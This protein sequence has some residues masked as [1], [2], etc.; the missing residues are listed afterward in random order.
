[1]PVPTPNDIAA[2]LREHADS[3]NH[4]HHDDN[5]GAY[6]NLY[7]EAATAIDELQDIVDKLP[8]CS[9]LGDDGEVVQDVPVVP[10]MTVWVIHRLNRLWHHRVSQMTE[11]WGLSNGGDIQW[12]HEDSYNTQAAA[13]AA[14]V[15]Q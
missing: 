2:A 1:M 15:T 13:E 4:D 6:P 9:R 12:R 10:G 7:R 14:R 11:S 8:K 3:F 5:R